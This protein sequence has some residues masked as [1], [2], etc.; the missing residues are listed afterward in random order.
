MK[1]YCQE[2]C[3]SEVFFF[4]MSKNVWG[5]YE[6]LC[7]ARYM[8]IE[9]IIPI[10]AHLVIRNIPA[11]FFKF[12]VILHCKTVKIAHVE[13]VI[14]GFLG[15]VWWFQSFLQL[16][17]CLYL[18]DQVKFWKKIQP[19]WCRTPESGPHFLHYG[20][21]KTFFPLLLEASQ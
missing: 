13:G 4:D 2:V 19:G 14:R 7:V 8:S 5:I 15:A 21:F 6:I 11:W 20:I 16:R 1:H 3:I 9:L 10:S 17:T 12:W 18:H